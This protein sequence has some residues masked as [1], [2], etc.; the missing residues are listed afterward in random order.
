[1]WG[2]KSSQQ[3]VEGTKAIPAQEVSGSRGGGMAGRVEHSWYGKVGRKSGRGEANWLAGEILRALNALPECES[4][5]F[6]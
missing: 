5:L 3:G 1:M 4:G 6:F 2:S